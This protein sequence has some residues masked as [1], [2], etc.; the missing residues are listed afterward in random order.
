MN[1]MGV[2][3]VF[4]G[5]G[6]GSLSRYGLSLLFR[7]LAWQSF[8]IATLSANLMSTAVLGWFVF[9]MNPAPSSVWVLFI[10]VGFCGGFST[11]STFSLETMQLMR[12]GQMTWALANIVVSVAACTILLFLFSKSMK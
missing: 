5:G 7:H 12:S 11:F 1:W 3:A 10:G 9:R 8:P 4:V 2:L 6:L